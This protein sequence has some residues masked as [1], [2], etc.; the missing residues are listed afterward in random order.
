LD[1]KSAL[2]VIDLTVFIALVLPGFDEGIKE[3][4]SQSITPAFAGLTVG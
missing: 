4:T 3:Q 2:W 1:F